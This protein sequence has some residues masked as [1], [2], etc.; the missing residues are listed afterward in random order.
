M[1]SGRVPDDGRTYLAAA[2]GDSPYESGTLLAPGLVL[3]GRTPTWVYPDFP[4]EPEELLAAD[5]PVLYS[6]S[7]AVVVDKPHGLPSTPN[8]RLLRATAQSLMRVRLQE[9]ELVAAHRLDRDTRGLLVLARNPVTRGFLQTQFQRREVSKTYQALAADIPEIG[10]QWQ[11]VQLPMLKI[12]DDP[13]V[14]VVDG[15]RSRLTVTRIRKLASSA[16]AE[17]RPV[18]AT[19]AGTPTAVYE[20]QPLTGYTHQLRV[21][22]NHLGAPIYG[23]DTY[24]EYRP[25]AGALRLRAVAI[26]LALVAS[27]KNRQRIE[28]ERCLEDPWAQ[29]GNWPSWRA[30]PR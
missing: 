16:G 30:G 22:M 3:A 4:E 23:D 9:P 14:K 17:A 28:I 18:E 20:L 13:Q 11:D 7:D 1:L 8:G 29:W 15:E 26:E 5:I 21:L 6:G 19:R 27:L 12:K 24:P 25:G 10:S 2:A